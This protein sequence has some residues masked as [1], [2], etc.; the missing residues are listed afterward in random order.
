MQVQCE[1]SI[2]WVYDVYITIF[3]YI[4]RCIYIDM[5]MHIV[6]QTTHKWRFR[7]MK[8]YAY[9]YYVQYNIQTLFCRF[10]YK[11]CIHKIYSC[12]TFVINKMSSLCNWCAIFPESESYYVYIKMLN[13]VKCLTLERQRFRK[14]FGGK[15]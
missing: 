7:W 9:V 15:K 4:T 13:S 14:R 2:S 6:I 10:T 1:N 5:Q 11:Y 3:A 8:N 12:V